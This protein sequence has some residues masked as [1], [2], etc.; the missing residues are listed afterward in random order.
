[1]PN[2]EPS[3]AASQAASPDPKQMELLRKAVVCLE[4]RLRECTAV[5]AAREVELTQAKLDCADLPAVRQRLEEAL[6]ARHALELQVHQWQRSAATARGQAED[7][8]RQQKSAQATA[9][10][11]RVEQQRQA[12]HVAQLR[13]DS[14]ALQLDEVR[15]RGQAKVLTDQVQQLELANG[16]LRLDNQAHAA[17]LK[18][19]YEREGQLLAELGEMQAQLRQERKQRNQRSQLAVAQTPATECPA[20]SACAAA[21]PSG[22]LEGMH[23]SL[24]FAAAAELTRGYSA[25]LEHAEQR[26]GQLEARLAAMTG[27]VQ[28]LQEG[29]AALRGKLQAA[30]AHCSRE[31]EVTAALLDTNLHLHETV[32]ALLGQG[33]ATVQPAEAQHMASPASE[34][35]KEAKQRRQSQD[36]QASESVHKKVM[37]RAA[38]KQG[39]IQAALRLSAEHR[40]L[41]ASQRHMAA[42]LQRMARS[43]VAAPARQQ[44]TVLR[45]HAQLQQEMVHVAAQLEETV[46]QLTATRQAGLI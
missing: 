32:V 30:Q 37:W 16:S 23:R 44:L 29:E 25:K 19:A 41:L 5:V 8:R 26:A 43:L 17:K 22:G 46:R 9:A 42:E 13:A 18:A 24:F 14:E 21:G 27:T 6:A 11:A 40:H 7:A 10:S 1:M 33:Q 4:K 20:S 39:A 45:Q 12:E 34:P 15:V 3:V 35:C 28:E 38:P 2:S 31:G 36:Q